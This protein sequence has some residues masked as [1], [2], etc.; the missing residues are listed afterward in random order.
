MLASPII[1]A[2]RTLSA[3]ARRALLPLFLAAL[4]AAHLFTKTLHWYCP[5]A[6]LTHHPCPTC[7]LSRATASFLVGD[8]RYAFG[9]Q[10]LF[11]VVVPF[12]MMV[13]T[14]ELATYVWT[15]ELGRW[16]KKRPIGVIALALAAALFALWIARFFGLFGGPVGV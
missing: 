13:A 4:G 16:T 1:T 2:P 3:R 14:L 9:Q 12:V 15:G 5:I 11:V 7:G 6:Q 8:Y 10:P